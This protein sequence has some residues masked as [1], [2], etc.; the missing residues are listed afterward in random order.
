M[1]VTQE[2]CRLWK[3]I[4]NLSPPPAQLA[5]QK[6]WLNFGGGF[7]DRF[8]PQFFQKGGSIPT[9]SEAKAHAAVYACVAIL[10]QEVARLRIKI[11]QT[12][13]DSSRRELPSSA[14]SLVLRRP[15]HYQTRSDFF[16]YMMD[17]LLLSGNAYAYAERSESGRII[18]LHPRPSSSVMPWVVP[19][20]GDIFYS[21]LKQDLDN[22]LV[23]KF[24]EQFLI[25]AR[26][27]LHI[28][29]GANAHPLIG[30][31]P[32]TGLQYAIP[33]GIAIQRDSTSFFSRMSRP[34]GV[35]VT[36]NELDASA[37][38]RLKKSWESGMSDNFQ[39]RTA[40]LDNGMTW[41]PLTMTAADSELISQYKM[42][43]EDIAMVYRIPLYML[44]DLTKATYKNVESMQKGFQAGS[45]GFYTEHIEA[46]IDQF[47][48]LDGKTYS[49]FDM[50]RG[51]VRTEFESRMSGLTKAIQG[52]VMTINEARKTESRGPVEGGDSTFLQRQNWPIDML[53]AD[54]EKELNTADPADPSSTGDDDDGDKAKVFKHITITGLEQPPQ[55]TVY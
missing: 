12:Q 9:N 15:N 5:E 3:P 31:T 29:I 44:G 27:I 7:Q 2:S 46:S 17:N 51:I 4:Q 41:Q 19:G 6:A 40:V 1:P 18:K 25:P 54:A 53:G 43:V 24:P 47:F 55:V 48:D 37:A 21:V 28:K 42:T 20:T 38:E 34:S 45:L 16:Q 23:Q 39:G 10:S 50:E 32:L 14:A 30:E 33:Q 22:K 11:F 13:D 35:L 52:G 49:E 36:P 8:D 26:D